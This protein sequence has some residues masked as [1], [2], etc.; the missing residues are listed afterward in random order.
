MKTTVDICVCTFRRP[1]LKTTLESLARQ[2]S[3]QEAVIRVIVADND[4]EPSAKAL[5]LATADR[6]GLEVTYLHAPVKNISI[7]RNACLDAATADW[8]AFIDDDEHA[9]PDWLSE[10]WQSAE[11]HGFDAVFGPVAAEYPQ[12]SPRWMVEGDFHSTEVVYVR[13]QILTGYTCN[14][15]MR[16]SAIER[17]ALRFD[18]R[19]GVS[20]GEDTD[21][22]G[23]WRQMGATYGYAPEAL[24]C[25]PVP[26]SRM[27]F[28][29]LW[30][31]RFRMG[32]THG[33]GL[34]RAGRAPLKVLKAMGVASAKAAYCLGNAML[35]PWQKTRCARWLLRGALHVG[36]VH[37]LTGASGLQLYR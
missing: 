22:F 6:V 5:V 20:G 16:R 23:R 26:P 9:A 19:F 32:Q 34:L 4:E 30:R 36:A 33:A 12:S 37:G 18:E 11:R 21:F 27:S 3:V 29:W 25:E 24:V 1:S 17:L 14:V 31:R 13:G 7:A 8:V 15:L 10:L 2:R 35:T 28:G